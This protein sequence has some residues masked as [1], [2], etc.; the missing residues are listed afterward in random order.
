MAIT[1][2]AADYPLLTDA[3]P[4]NEGVWPVTGRYADTHNSHNMKQHMAN[5]WKPCL[6]VIGVA[7]IPS[8]L[9]MAGNVMYKDMTLR[10]SMRLAPTQKW[11]K[12]NALLEAKL[13]E[14]SASTF[15]AKLEY[16]LIDGGDGFK[17]P[18]LPY[19]IKKQLDAA[20]VEIFGVGNEPL[21]VGCGG[22]I[23]FMDIF[24]KEFPQASFMLTGACMVSSNA[25]SANE[26]L[27][28]QYCANLTSVIASTLSKL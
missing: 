26:N 1:K 24:T 13:T 17:A 12:I 2:L 28:L 6:S 27:D 19:P 8:D 14:A 9:A 21:S 23:P 10:C 4:L 20:T 7:G 11:E 5:W 18:D 25:H 16:T 15:G 22:A 3:L